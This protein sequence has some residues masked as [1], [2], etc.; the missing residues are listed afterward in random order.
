M[1]ICT[2]NKSFIYSYPASCLKV[3]RFRAEVERLRGGLLDQSI[4]HLLLPILTVGV[5]LGLSSRAH[6][7]VGLLLF[8]KLARVEMDS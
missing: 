8:R 3:E 4:N 2:I 5:C 6:L 1:D 7:S